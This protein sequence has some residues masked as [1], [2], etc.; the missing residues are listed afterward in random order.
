MLLIS[1]FNKYGYTF[2]EDVYHFVLH[3]SHIALA[4]LFS[5]SIYY[6]NFVGVFHTICDLVRRQH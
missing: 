2:Y 4:F 1:L 6:R 3:L 5:L